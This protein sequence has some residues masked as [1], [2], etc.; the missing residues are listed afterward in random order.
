MYPGEFSNTDIEPLELRSHLSD[1]LMGKTSVPVTVAAW[2]VRSAL[3][4]HV[5]RVL[6]GASG[7]QMGNVAAKRLVA[8]MADKHPL[9][10]RAVSQNIRKSMGSDV[11][12]YCAEI[13]VP[14]SELGSCP[15]PTIVGAGSS[16]I[17][18]KALFGC[19]FA[20]DHTILMEMDKAYWVALYAI[21][22]SFGMAGYPHIL[23]ASTLAF[24]VRSKQAVFSH[25]RGILLRVFREVWNR[26]KIRLH[27]KFTLSGVVPGMLQHRPVFVLA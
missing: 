17:L 20:P 16:Y 24:A 4:Y 9:G 27:Q 7:K 25:P 13:A 2:L 8:S 15:Q 23:A 14:V 21:I 1:L 3:F 10:D 11:P 18:P 12:S 22:G 26:C 6:F 5:I 19:S